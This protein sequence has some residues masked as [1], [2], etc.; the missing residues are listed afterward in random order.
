MR[1][2]RRQARK[3]SKQGANRVRRLVKRQKADNYS[4][5]RDDPAGPE[6]VSSP[7]TLKPFLDQRHGPDATAAVQ[8]PR[9]GLP[10]YTVNQ[11]FP[12]NGRRLLIDRPPRPPAHAPHSPQSEAFMTRYLISAHEFNVIVSSPWSF[13][14]LKVQ[15]PI[16]GLLRRI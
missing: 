16:R 10:R 5:S 9:F 14:L 1:G 8:P 3:R 11:P 4:T 7:S 2:T 13:F 15:R 12:P 6:S